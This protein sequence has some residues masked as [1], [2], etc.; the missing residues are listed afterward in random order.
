VATSWFI[1]A[2]IETTK[3]QG[4]ALI[5]AQDMKTLR[6]GCLDERA[7]PMHSASIGSAEREAVQA[8]R[9]GNLGRAG[10]RSGKTKSSPFL[11]SASAST[12]K[13]RGQALRLLCQ[14]VDCELWSQGSRSG[15]AA[16]SRTERPG[17]ALPNPSLK[18]RPIGKTPA[19]R[20]SAE[21]HLQ[22]GAGVSPSVPA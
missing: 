1:D 13:F 6:S 9:P 19:P 16:R 4:P 2:V 3:L 17:K 10:S 12:Q 21:H 20:Y 8:R 7:K 22:R 11:A 18:P 5:E 15:S 14:P